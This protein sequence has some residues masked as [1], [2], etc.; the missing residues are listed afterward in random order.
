M[1]RLI[2]T[3]LM[4]LLLGTIGVDAIAQKVVEQAPAEQT[5]LTLNQQ[6]DQI[7]AADS[8]SWMFWRYDRGSARNA[9]FEGDPAESSRV[10]YGEYSF[11]GGQGGWVRVRFNAESVQ[12]IQFWNEAQCRP[13]R[14]P[15]SHRIVGDLLA[16][17]ASGA[18]N[19]SSGSTG[20]NCRYENM[21]GIPGGRQRICN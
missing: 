5:R 12:C 6:L 18:A 3:M 10:L 11:N 15:P 13:F 20:Q 14:S 21:P 1:T 8:T 9:R 16:S 7:I 2:L 19:G 4:P 17:A